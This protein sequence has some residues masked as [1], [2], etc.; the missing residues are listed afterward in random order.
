MQARRPRR[1]LD[2]FAPERPLLI[3]LHARLR[4]KRLLILCP[5]PRRQGLFALSLLHQSRLRG[6]LPLHHWPWL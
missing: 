4:S 6:R 1:A 3:F 5:R 2:M